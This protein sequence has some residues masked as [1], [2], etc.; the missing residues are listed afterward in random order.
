MEVLDAIALFDWG[1]HSREI[2]EWVDILRDQ[3]ESD[4]F[5]E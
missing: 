5:D 3:L 2:L 1:N 4:A